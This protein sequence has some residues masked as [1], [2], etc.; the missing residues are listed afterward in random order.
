MKKSR[1]MLA[2]ATGVILAGMSTGIFA[3]LSIP[4][5][6]ARASQLPEAAAWMPASASFVA[7]LDVDSLLASPLSD[8]WMARQET[9]EETEKFREATGL[10]PWNDFRALSISSRMSEDGKLWGI[11]LSGEL[12]PERLVS[13]IE[14]HRRLERSTYQDTTLYTFNNET[15]EGKESHALAF[16]GPAT[17]LFGS[18]EQVRT[19]LDVGAGRE[20]AAS[21]GPLGRWLVELP[22]DET[23]WCVG[24][25]DA[26][27]DRLMLR[28]P[29]DSPSVPPLQSFAISGQLAADINILARGEAADPEAALKLVDVVRGFVALGSLQHQAR[30]EVGAVLDSIRIE[31]IDNR[32][33]ASLSVPYD[34]IR[35]LASQS[36]EPEEK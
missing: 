27:F 33:E 3:Y 4:G 23:F 16:P 7:Y 19:M 1:L 17:A 12:D 5:T 22:L 31:S 36:R 13:V 26:G 28:A 34:T 8:E 9:L 35:R 14:E 24:S 32:V 6:N 29:S 15:Q 30:P 2:L 20:P 10:D 25:A 18:P 21:D 11:A